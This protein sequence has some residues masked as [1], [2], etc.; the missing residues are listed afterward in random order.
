MVVYCVV[1]IV[2]MGVVCV[3][4]IDC[5]GVCVGVLLMKCVLLGLY[6]LLV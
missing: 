5:D 4:V 2:I 3:C 6:V 1:L